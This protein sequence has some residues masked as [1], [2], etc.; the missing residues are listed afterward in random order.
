MKTHHLLIP[1]NIIFPISILG[2]IFTVI[3]TL[4]KLSHLSFG[5]F[6]PNLVLSIS[7]V[8]SL[9]AIFV[10]LLDII[11]NPLKNKFLWIIPLL[12]VGNI[13]SMIYLMNREAHLRRALR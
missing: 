8:F 10:V 3:G 7:M 1:K 9:F 11:K 13:V 4:L 12:F 6:T 5:I 2:F